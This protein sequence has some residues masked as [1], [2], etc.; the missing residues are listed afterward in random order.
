MSDSLQPHG[1]YVAHRVPLSVDFSRQEHQSGQ[2][3]PSPGDLPHP[4]IETGSPTLQVVAGRLFMSE[5]PGK[6]QSIIRYLFILKL[7]FQ[8]VVHTE[9]KA[10]VIRVKCCTKISALLQCRGDRGWNAAPTKTKFFF[11]FFFCFFFQFTRKKKRR[12]EK[13]E[14]ARKK[15]WGIRRRKRLS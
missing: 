7:P 9:Q 10:V 11:V 12:N 13:G 2:I 15:E 3:F 5:P 1:L 8:R 6:P 14:G 4:G